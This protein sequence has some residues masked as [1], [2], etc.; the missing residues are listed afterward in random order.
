MMHDEHDEHDEHDDHGDNLVSLVESLKVASY[1]GDGKGKD[2]NTW[3][4]S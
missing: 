2:K 1:D 4:F 3:Q